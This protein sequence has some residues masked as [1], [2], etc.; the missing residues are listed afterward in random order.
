VSRQPHG[1]SRARRLAVSAACALATAALAAPAQASFRGHPGRLYY[2]ATDGPNWQIFSSRSNGDDPVNL[3]NST[4]NDTQPRVSKDGQRIVF[5]SDRSGSQQ[6]WVMRADGSR[7]HQLTS[8]GTAGRP[9]WTASGLIVF[10][11]TR[12]GN[13]DVYRMN[14]DGSQQIDL[15][16]NTADDR[17]PAPAPRGDELAFTS[18]RSGEYHLYTMRLDGSGV[19]QVT[20]E[21]GGQ[22]LA[23]WSPDG[24]QLSF[25]AFVSDSAIDNDLWA[26]NVDGTGLRQLTDTPDRVEFG[27]AW[28]PNGRHIVFDGCTQVGTPPQQQCLVYELPAKGGPATLLV[29]HTF[30]DAFDDGVTDPFWFVGS[31]GTGGSSVETNGHLEQAIAADAVV[32][33]STRYL[34]SNY[35]GRCAMTGDFDMRATYTLLD[36]PATNGVQAS[37]GTYS[38][39]GGEGAAIRES[40]TWGELYSGYFPPNW[41]SITT[42]ARSGTLR[43]VRSGTISTAYYR[44]GRGW[45]EIASGIV[46]GQ[47][48][49]PNISIATQ[50][51]RFVHQLVRVAWSDFSATAAGWQCPTSWQE[52]Q[53]DWSVAAR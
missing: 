17:Q 24:T 39:A 4:S 42:S 26:I 41:L 9:A 33:P 38:P 40:Q 1:S 43:V 20:S 32:D 35:F 5:T 18:N 21:A 25:D 51:E 30:S 7:Q 8:Q 27:S 12:S 48:A 19:T 6:I 52:D 10:Q 45:Q 14:A 31:D 46:S 11:S 22:Q 23:S 44:V 34:F 36:W 50:D 3:S 29:H 37:I 16:S 13:L 47:P 2:A 15:T 28:S 53:P 49:N